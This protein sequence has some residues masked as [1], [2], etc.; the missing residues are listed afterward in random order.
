MPCG[1]RPTAICTQTAWRFVHT[2]AAIAFVGH[3]VDA[4]ALRVVQTMA[5]RGGHVRWLRSAKTRTMIG[6]KSWTRHG[7]GSTAGPVLVEAGRDGRT[8]RRQQR[9]TVS[10]SGAQIDGGNMALLAGRTAR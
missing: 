10:R 7:A 3:V 2:D 8:D 5:V 9:S 6:S 1:P 4:V